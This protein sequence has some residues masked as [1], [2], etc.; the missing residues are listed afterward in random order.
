MARKT[1]YSFEKRQ[2]E[3]ARQEKKDQKLKR[4]QDDK[5]Q[6]P[7]DNDAGATDPE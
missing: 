5:D 4:K 1:S 6:A 3:L 7:T 2:K